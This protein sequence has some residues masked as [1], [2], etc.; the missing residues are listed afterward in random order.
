MTMMEE[1]DMILSS[2]NP[3]MS[4]QPGVFSKWFDTGAPTTQK[5]VNDSQDSSTCSPQTK[6]QTRT[7]NNKSK[8]KKRRSSSPKQQHEPEQVGRGLYDMAEAQANLGHYEKAFQ[9]WNEALK[10]QK[11]KLGPR[12]PA[13]A[14][15]LARRGSTSARLGHWYPAALDLE[16]AAHIY[17]SRGEDALASDALIQ[18]AIAQERMGHLDEAVANMEAALAVKKELRDEESVARLNCLIGN[19]RH[20][21]RDYEQ[22]L[23]SFRIGLACYEQAGVDKSHPHVVWAAR[24]ASD[25]S[26]QGHLFFQAITP[27]LS[28]RNSFDDCSK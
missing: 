11:E 3:T 12:H 26:I 18:L 8:T 13:V 22:A 28:R 5:A 16:T 25:R 15:T 4:G 1:D 20:Q 6:K 10:L 19:I 7:S 9:L 21:Q 2:M 14:C 24:R 23:Q 17:Q 27:P